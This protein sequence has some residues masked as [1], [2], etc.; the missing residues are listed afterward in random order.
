M[1]LPLDHRK[2]K[3]VPE[4][5]LLLLHWL[6]QSLWLCGS[7]QNEKFLKRWEHQTPI[8]ILRNL[9]AG[10]EAGQEQVEPDMEQRTGSK[11]G[12]EYFKA[13]HCQ[14]AYLTYMQSKSCEMPGWMKHK[15]ESKL[16]GEISVNSDMQKT[17]TAESKEEL[18]SLLMRVK[19]GSEKTW[20]KTQHSKNKNH[21]IH[22]HHFMA[23]RW[24]NR[25]NS[26]WL[27]LFGLQNHCRWWLQPWN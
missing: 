21:G 12:K 26:D 15:L 9:Y 18:K 27:Y 25:G 1:N 10:Q 4:K 16:P 17:L 14:P 5:H 8:C 22:S 11:L 2:S 20:L 3:R 24:R 13:V 6:R 23:N 19:E 7:Q